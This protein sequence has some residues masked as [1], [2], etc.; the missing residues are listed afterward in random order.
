MPRS[1][2]HLV[3]NRR[4]LLVAAA[5]VGVLAVGGMLGVWLLGGQ[6]QPASELLAAREVTVRSIDD[7]GEAEHATAVA[8]AVARLPEAFG[9]GDTSGLSASAKAEFGDVSTALLKGS[10]LTVHQASWRRTGSVASAVATLAVSGRPP[11]TFL[12]VMT[13]EDGGWKLSS[14]VEVPTA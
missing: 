1:Y 3:V 13:F 7:P 6:P 4:V 9:R 5:A 12:V 8:A 11:S 14:T 2:R 10:V